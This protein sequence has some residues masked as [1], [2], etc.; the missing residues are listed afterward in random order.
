MQQQTYTYTYTLLRYIH[1]T[2]AGE[3]INVGVALFAPDA[4]FVAVRCRKTYARLKNVF[5]DMDGAAFRSAM[6]SIELRFAEFE[7]RTSEEL[8]L[9]GKSNVLEYARMVLPQDDGSLQWSPFG[10][11]LTKDP[12]KTLDQL[13]TRM[14]ERYDAHHGDEKRTDD[15]V[16]RTFKHTLD[17]YNLPVQFEPHTVRAEDD[18]VT[19]R[20]AWKNGIWH[21]VEPVSFDLA[22]AE[23]IRDKAHLW[24]GQATGVKEAGDQFKVYFVVG[25]P[26]SESLHTAFE[27]ALSILAKV[28]VSKTIVDENAVESIVTEITAE[29]KSHFEN[30]PL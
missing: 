22:T 4:N 26:Q 30:K 18:E 23:N 13:Y 6:R 20:F 8:P 11:G 16:W 15:D 12:S 25:R 28:P 29:I 27:S 10:S 17:I 1:D 19:F 14:I 9:A 2:T 7:R 3:A 5:P 24:L 21:C